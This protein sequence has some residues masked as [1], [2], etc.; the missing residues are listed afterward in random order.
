MPSSAVHLSRSGKLG[1]RN[2]PRNISSTPFCTRA[3][4]RL[5]G[6]EQKLAKMA[7]MCTDRSVCT[8][9]CATSMSTSST[10][11][12]VLTCILSALMLR[13]SLCR[14]WHAANWMDSSWAL[15][16]PQTIGR[17]PES[18]HCRRALSLFADRSRTKLS[19][20]IPVSSSPFAMHL[21]S[22][23]TTSSSIT[24]DANLAYPSVSRCIGVTASAKFRSSKEIRSISVASTSI[25]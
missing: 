24:V 20:A 9:L 2:T 23:G 14:H 21:M 13:E 8:F 16:L 15:S 17:M 4:R 7:V 11:D 12:V 19:V 5:F 18:M 1:D 22:L 6:S 25:W 3:S 10:S